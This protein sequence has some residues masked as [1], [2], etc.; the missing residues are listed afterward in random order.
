MKKFLLLIFVVLL[1]QIAKNQV[2]SD[3][4]LKTAYIYNFAQNIEWPNE[5]ELKT[6]KIGILGTDSALYNNLSLLAT[7]KTLRGLQ[8]VVV[9]FT[10]MQEVLNEKPQLVYLTYEKSQDIK[11]IFYEIIQDRKSVV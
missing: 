4:Q 5:K 1:N 9:K 8:I 11:Q 10:E 6:F 7:T 2:Y 3:A